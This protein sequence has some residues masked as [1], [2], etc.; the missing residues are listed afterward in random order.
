MPPLFASSVAL[1][2][3]G[4]LDLGLWRIG[5]LVLLAGIGAWLDWRTRRLPN[6]LCGATFL[7]GLGVAVITVG[8][9]AAALQVWHAALALLVGMALFAPGLI[10][11]GDAKFYAAVAVWFPLAEGFR[12][13]FLVALAG[14]VLTVALWGMV[15]RRHG[16][17]GAGA[18]PPVPPRTVP[19]GVA[20]AAGALAGL[21]V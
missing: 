3:S 13:L 2:D 12:L 15:W 7:A 4:L 11:G 6:W 9:A 21:V 10:G 5:P 20:I 18:D 17:A 19:Y 16:R 1:P 14:L 8:L